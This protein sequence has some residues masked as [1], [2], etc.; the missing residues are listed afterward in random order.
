MNYALLFFTLFSISIVAMEPAKIYWELP[1]QAIEMIA[2]Q[3]V[4]NTCATHVDREIRNLTLINK[5]WHRAINS[6]QVFKKIIHSI[7]E[8]KSNA[9]YATVD[10]SHKWKNM[11][12]FKHPEFQ[13]WLVQEKERLAWEDKFLSTVQSGGQIALF[14]E[15]CKEDKKRFN[16]NAINKQGET[17]LYLSITKRIENTIALIS[18]GADINKKRKDGCTPLKRSVAYG[19][20][21]MV[22]LLLSHKADPNSGDNEQWTPLITAA[23]NGNNTII[24]ELMKVNAD[25]NAQTNKGWT[26]L[27]LATE[28]QHLSVV[29][30]LVKLGAALD[31]KNKDGNTALDIVT[32]KCKRCHY[33]YSLSCR[34][35]EFLE[36]AESKMQV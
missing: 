3:L 18:A 30:K 12:V 16:I 36:N 10:F 35:I 13:E 6:P 15:Q 7:A 11:P 27:M 26:A 4:K 21:E 29:Q 17:A 28:H 25:L 32:K 23:C 31:L 20:I 22:K 14:L 5:T 33:G 8:S 1:D 2:L 24:K 9:T 34:I 19:N